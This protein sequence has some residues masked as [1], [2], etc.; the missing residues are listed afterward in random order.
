LLQ[1]DTKRAI[2]YL[3]SLSILVHT[4]LQMKTNTS[5]FSIIFV[6]VLV[7]TMISAAGLQITLVDARTSSSRST[8][9]FSTGGSNSKHSSGLSQIP[10]T[11]N[12]FPSNDAAAIEVH[13]TSAKKDIIGSY[14]VKGEI[15][16]TGTDALKFVRVTAHFY[17]GSGQLVASSTCCYTTPS[18]IDAGRTA[19]FDSFVQSADISGKPT[20]Y[21]LS[22]DWQ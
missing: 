16:N 2:D 12:D 4:I 20:S 15:T 9:T 11:A 1:Q 7:M 19:T 3:E 14:H 13:V 5:M 17:D 10:S 18:D 22:F 6:A 21:R 8:F